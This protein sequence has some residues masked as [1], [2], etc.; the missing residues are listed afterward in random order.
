MCHQIGSVTGECDEDTGV[1]ECLPGVGGDKCD[2]CLSN[3]YGMTRE[4][5][6]GEWRQMRF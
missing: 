2:Q 6:K 1:C 5:C 4:G 3:H